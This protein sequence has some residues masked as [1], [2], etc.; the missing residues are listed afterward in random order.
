MFV[1]HETSYL[2]N[3]NLTIK[4]SDNFRDSIKMV[5]F[6]MLILCQIKFYNKTTKIWLKCD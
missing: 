2:I 6:N 5:P 1:I 3:N 4:S